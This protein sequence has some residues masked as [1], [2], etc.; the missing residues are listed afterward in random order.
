MKQGHFDVLRD[1][2]LVQ[3]FSPYMEPEGSSLGSKEPSL[4][5]IL[6]PQKY[7]ERTRNI[8]LCIE[9]IMFAR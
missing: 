8:F 6:G 7:K 1:V 4:Y 9:I 5:P 3:K 2:E